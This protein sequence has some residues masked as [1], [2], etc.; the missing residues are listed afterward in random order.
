MLARSLLHDWAWGLASGLQVQRFCA[1]AVADGATHPLL[2]RLG[3]LGARGSCPQNVPSQL[4][5]MFKRNVGGDLVVPLEASRQSVMIYPHAVVKALFDLSP[6]SFR[7][8]VGANRSALREFWTCYLNTP[9]GKRHQRLHPHL[10]NKTPADLECSF[11]I[12]MHNDAGPV[13]RKLSAYV[14]SWASIFGIGS[15]IECR[16]LIASWMPDSFEG[17]PERV[18]AECWKS[19]CALAS[20]VVPEGFEG[21]GSYLALDADGTIWKGI[22]LTSLADGEYNQNVIGMNGAS[23][24]EPCFLCRCNRSTHPFTALGTSAK[25]METRCSNEEFLNRVRRPLHGMAAWPCFSKYMPRFDPLHVTD[26]KGVAGSIAGNV[27]SSVLRDPRFFVVFP[28][29]GASRDGR[30]AAINEHLKAWERSHRVSNRLPKLTVNIIFKDGK[31]NSFPHLQGPGV[32]ASNT[33]ECIPWVRALALLFDDGS[34]FARH[35]LRIV[36]ALDDW[37]RTIYSSSV[38]L[39]DEQFCSQRKHVVDCMR[40]YGWLAYNARC[41]GRFEFQVLPKFHWF[42]ELSFQARLLNPRYQQTYQGE[43]MVGRVATIYKRSLKGPY[44]RTIQNTIMRKYALGLE[45]A[46]IDFD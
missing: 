7:T 11:P 42:I 28:G 20:G 36:Q 41:E 16:F 3:R 4:L 1:H 24:A 12:S 34:L 18:W 45:A 39:S 26:Y 35:R 33:R 38:V 21:A 23:H 15:E 43:S 27:I 19:F 30:I 13:S 37:Y 46:L 14:L 31:A 10:R 17:L 32:K 6:S 5:R 22:V 8:R 9:D 44:Q 25:W 2:H 29:S 40:S